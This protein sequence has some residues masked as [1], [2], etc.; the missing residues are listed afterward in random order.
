M[1]G[2]TWP[3]GLEQNRSNLERFIQYELD[4]GLIDDRLEVE[5]LF[6]PSCHSL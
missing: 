4:Q 2:D 6:H 3:N 1:G 5:D